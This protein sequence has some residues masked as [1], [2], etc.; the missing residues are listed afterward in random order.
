METNRIKQDGTAKDLS[1]WHDNIMG[2]DY[3]V[4]RSGEFPGLFQ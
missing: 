2:S 3:N 1:L 4:K